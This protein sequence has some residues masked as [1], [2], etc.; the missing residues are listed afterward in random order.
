MYYLW[1]CSSLSYVLGSLHRGFKGAS[2]GFC[3]ISLRCLFLSNDVFMS[4]IS[5]PLVEYDLM[6][7]PSSSD[8]FS[9]FIPI[10]DYVLTFFH[11]E[12]EHFEYLFDP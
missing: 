1:R 8:V 5:Q 11:N 7:P 12:L 10:Y 3:L 4:I 9:R 6:D 2:F